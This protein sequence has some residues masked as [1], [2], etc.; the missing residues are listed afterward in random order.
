MGINLHIHPDRTTLTEAV[1]KQA[2]AM[3]RLAIVS[4]GSAGL[5]LSGDPEVEGVVD[6]LASREGLDWKKVFIFPVC[7]FIG[8]SKVSR[9]SLQND[10]YKKIIAANSDINTKCLI[11][12]EAIP[13]TE[14]KRISE[15]ISKVTPVL[16]LTG[17]G[18]RGEIGLTEQVPKNQDESG[19]VL[20]EPGETFRKELAHPKRFK[21][22]HEVP[23]K[24]ITISLKSLMA[25]KNIITCATGRSKSGLATKLATNTQPELPCQ[26]LSAHP[27]FY[28]HLDR[29]AASG[30]Q[31][32]ES[33]S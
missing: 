32:S 23:R 8:L 25:S 21:N 27:N 10:F 13:S 18:Q 7:E 22:I 11:N 29:D 30:I 3:L 16:V 14:I 26:L 31:D 24:G 6:F 20:A 2:A 9:G 5:I 4:A 12:G 28:L 1:G 33:K 17:V 19:Y 15:C